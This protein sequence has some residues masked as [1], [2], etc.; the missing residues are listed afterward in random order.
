MEKKETARP[1]SPKIQSLAGVATLAG[2]PARHAIATFAGGCFWCTEAIFQRLTGVRSVLPGYSGGETKNP[3]YEDVCSGKTGHAECIQVEFDPK[4]LS[5]QELL[6]VFFKLHDPTTL[7]RQGN[8][9]GSQYR[10]VVF[11][12]SKEQKQIAE[13]AK[14]EASKHYKD[15]IVTKISPFKK[16]YVAEDYHQNYFNN[17]RTQPYC[18]AVID[19]KIKKLFENYSQKLKGDYKNS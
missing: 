8:D 3:S 13:K 15:P 14:E 2:G 9:V 16:F 5:Y 12:H 17:N 11:Y 19:P 1:T 18:Q 6:G 10:S 4:I 7:N